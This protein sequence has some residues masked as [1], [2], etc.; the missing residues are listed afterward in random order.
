MNIR[1]ETVERHGRAVKEFETDVVSAGRDAANDLAFA[2]DSH[3]GVSRRHAEFRRD[4]EAWH[5]H[6]LGSINGTYVNRRRVRA[7]LLQDGDA[8]RFGA[9]GPEVRVLLPGS[10]GRP[11]SPPAQHG[12]PLRELGA[13]DLAP[14]RIG[15]PSLVD[16]GY[17]P[18]ALL[19][20]GALAAIPLCSRADGDP[21]VFTPHEALM[22]FKILTV[23]LTT[24]S[25]Y[26]IHTV[27]GKQKPWWLLAAVAAAITVCGDAVLSI[28][29]IPL[30]PVASHISGCLRLD[31]PCLVAVGKSDLVTRYLFHLLVAAIPEEIT[32]VAPVLAFGYMTI[33]ANQTGETGGWW[34][35]FRV[36]EPLDGILIA[37]ASAAGFTALEAPEYIQGALNEGAVFGAF[38]QTTDRSLGHLFGH[39]AY[40]GILGY[41]VGLA[42]MR[43]AE[44]PR[45]LGTGAGIAM[46]LHATWNAWAGEAPWSF[47]F[48]ALSYALLAVCIIHARKMSPARADNFATTMSHSDPKAAASFEGVRS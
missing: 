34:S 40:S 15:F 29:R 44:A 18:H 25:V 27:C 3:A 6:D 31:G 30:W 2:H 13:T 5:V 19:T 39:G 28:L 46:G 41:Y 33:R 21:N 22:A 42:L 26:A 37:F 10:A 43:R 24:L 14:W 36:S 48:T 16:K 11:A 35:A 4:G 32:K 47:F 23:Y 17:L 8:V 45:L 12:E 9:Q 7:A 1:I 20:M 38:L